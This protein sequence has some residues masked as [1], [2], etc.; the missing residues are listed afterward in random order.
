MHADNLLYWRMDELIALDKSL[1]LSWNGSDSLFLDGFMWMY[2]TVWLWIPLGI[3]LLVLILR[4]NDARNSILIFILIALLVLAADRFSAGFCKPFFHRFR[5]TH[6]P[7]IAYLIDIVNNYRGGKYG[8]ISSHACNSFALFTF[9]A[10]LFRNYAYSICML[11]WAL[12]NCYSRIYLGVHFPGDILFGALSGLIL[13]AVFHRIYLFLSAKLMYS[14][15]RSSYRST[16]ELTPSGYSIRQI[17]SFISLFFL[18]IIVAM[19][20]GTIFM[21]Q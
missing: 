16:R 15:S 19:I 3:M 11:A 2:S 20:A 12:I 13:G 18:L 4:N 5:P 6:D 10:L 7:E 1:L 14:T 17:Y 9:T 21:N 8:F